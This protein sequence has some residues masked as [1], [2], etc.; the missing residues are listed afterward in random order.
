MLTSPLT[1]AIA[2]ATIFLNI[3]F[4]LGGSYGVPYIPATYDYI[5]VGGGTAGLTLAARLAANLS[6][7]VAVIEAGGDYEIEFPALDIPGTAALL[8][9]GASTYDLN[10][11]IDWGFITEKMAVRK[12]ILP[13]RKYNAN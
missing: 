13:A 3:P 6:I 2:L 8:S 11:I 5:I 1:K 10:P 9:T 4:A 7:S 12:M